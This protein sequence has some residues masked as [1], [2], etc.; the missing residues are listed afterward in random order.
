MDSAPVDTNDNTTINIGIS[1]EPTPQAEQLILQA[2]NSNS[3][4]P[5]TNRQQLQ[6]SRQAKQLFLL[7]K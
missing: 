4:V 5:T 7:T 6:Q 3:L 2:R 1:I